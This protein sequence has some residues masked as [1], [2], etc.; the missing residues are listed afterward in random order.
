MKYRTMD[1]LCA[2]VDLLQISMGSSTGEMETTVQSI[3]SQ[4][5]DI[6]NDE[7]K[8]TST[9]RGDRFSAIFRRGSDMAGLA[10]AARKGHFVYGVLDLFQVHWCAKPTV[11]LERRFVDAILQVV[12]VSEHSFLRCKALE[13]LAKVSTKSGISRSPM[14]SLVE[15]LEQGSGS[16]RAKVMGQ[17]RVIRNKI[18]LED[19]EREDR[20]RESWINRG[21]RFDVRNS[22]MSGVVQSV[23]TFRGRQLSI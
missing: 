4:L 21:L 2:C 23:R 17:W 1:D 8:E 22:E 10:P 15:H 12:E 16:E 20:L 5:L 9:F 6:L 18:L 13:V 14:T 7:L 19:K 11:K 3:A